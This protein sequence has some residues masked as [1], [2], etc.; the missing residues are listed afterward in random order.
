MPNVNRYEDHYPG[1]EV[2]TWTE[3]DERERREMSTGRHFDYRQQAWVPGHDHAHHVTGPLAFCGT[4]LA[5]C[6]VRR[7]LARG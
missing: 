2:L 3:A 4:D 5:T 1:A 7:E 6:T